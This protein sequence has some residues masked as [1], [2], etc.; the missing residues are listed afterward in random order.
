LLAVI[1]EMEMEKIINKIIH[2]GEFFKRL[3]SLRKKDVELSRSEIIHRINESLPEGKTIAEGQLSDYVNGVKSPSAEI[4]ELMIE[5]MGE[6]AGAVYPWEEIVVIP[7]R[8]EV[9]EL[10]D[11]IL[12]LSPGHF[13]FSW[14]REVFRA[15]RYLIIGGAVLTWM[16]IY[17]YWE[18]FVDRAVEKH[19]RSYEEEVV[20][21]D[22]RIKDLEGINASKDLRI[23]GLKKKLDQKNKSLVEKGELDKEFGEKIRKAR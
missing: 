3:K 21:R 4:R 9:R 15:V 1:L 14:R 18:P 10:K 20:E 5:I 19:F 6:E 12:H 22:I 11:T 17:I 13:K 7:L 23:K 8:K 2:C 16:F